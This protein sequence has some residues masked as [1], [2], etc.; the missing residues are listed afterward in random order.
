MST[1]RNT[2][3]YYPNRFAHDLF[4]AMDEVMGKHGLDA[5][6]GMA[7]LD[8]YIDNPPPDDL[9][10]GFSFESIA[11]L[12]RALD[13]M[14]GQR[15]GRGMAIRAGRAWFAEGMK[16]FG[17]LRG[18]GDPAFRALPLEERCRLSLNAITEI[19]T[20]FSD[21]ATHLE[22][23]GAF[24]RVVASPSPFAYGRRAE[25]PVCHPLVGLLQEHLR[26]ASN[27][28]EFVVRETHC[29][30]TG[31]SACIFVINKHPTG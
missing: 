16:S 1:A 7:G 24:F 23:D 3:L 2:P 26:W 12:N 15:G 9:E 18:I 27:G 22:E 13:E 14:Y 11:G 21:Q 5:T 28:R 30:A 17:A 25:R 6:L 31:E 8:A 29:A 20:R 4:A 19:F 10:R